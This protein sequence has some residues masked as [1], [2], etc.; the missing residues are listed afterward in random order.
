[1]ILCFQKVPSSENKKNSKNIKVNPP[2]SCSPVTATDWYIINQSSIIIRESLY[3]VTARCCVACKIKYS[4]SSMYHHQSIVTSAFFAWLVACSFFLLSLLLLFF[5]RSR[6]LK[7]AL[8]LFYSC[9]I[10]VRSIYQSIYCTS[11][12]MIDT[13]A[14]S[15]STRS[16]LEYSLYNNTSIIFQA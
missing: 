4:S 6:P 7:R 9:I 14:A 13:A 3:Q 5:L 8:S 12:H 2:S 15:S 16:S 10:V 1:M 11:K